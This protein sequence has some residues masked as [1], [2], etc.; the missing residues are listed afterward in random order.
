MDKNYF[1]AMDFSIGDL[2][3]SLNQNKE[4]SKDLGSY[5]KGEVQE[6]ISPVTDRVDRLEK[7]IDLLILATERVEKLLVTIQPLVKI[8]NKLPFLK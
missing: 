8:V 2:V 4:G 6:A 7:K 5:L 3:S 1:P